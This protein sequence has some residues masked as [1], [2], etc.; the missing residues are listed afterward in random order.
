MATHWLTFLERPDT[1]LKMDSPNVKKVIDYKGF[2]IEPLQFGFIIAVY[3]I[4]YI[5]YFAGPRGFNL[6]KK[7]NDAKVFRTRYYCCELIDEMIRD[8]AEWISTMG[9]PAT[10]N[11]CV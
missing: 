5:L 11:E 1:M 7:R 4:K 3:G 6:S 8:H 9:K 2:T 10:K